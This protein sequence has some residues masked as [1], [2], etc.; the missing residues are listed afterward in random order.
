MRIYLI[1]TLF[2]MTSCVATQGEW[3]YR[4]L[5][6]KQNI[7]LNQAQSI[8][9]GK[10]NNSALNA[11][12][13]AADKTSI[14]CTTT[15]YMQGIYNTS[16]D[17]TANAIDI[18]SARMDNQK[19]QNTVRQ[20]TYSSCMAQNGW[21][22]TWLAKFDGSTPSGKDGENYNYCLDTTENNLV[23]CQYKDGL[24][25]TKPECNCTLLGGKAIN[26]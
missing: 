5:S 23:K 16:C 14:N 21:N 3:V 13:R 6:T 20:N 25:E 17:Q 11:P 4:K 7:S 9:S 18:L 10:A 2:F 1:F 15:S 12:Y 8:C 22:A 19:V 24:I 26:S